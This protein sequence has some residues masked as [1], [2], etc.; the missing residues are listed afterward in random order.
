MNKL[1]NAF[2]DW[3]IEVQALVH[4]VCIT[5]MCELDTHELAKKGKRLKGSK[6]SL[7]WS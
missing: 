5:D 7:D 6:E 3:V 2:L 4:A 1:I